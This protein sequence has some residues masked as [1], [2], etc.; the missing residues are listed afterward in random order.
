[1]IAGGATV[2]SAWADG[3]GADGYVRDL[4]EV[5]DLVLSLLAQRKGGK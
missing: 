2:N 3:I 5:A 1:M 4:R